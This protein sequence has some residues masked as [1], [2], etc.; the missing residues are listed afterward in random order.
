MAGSS[1]RGPLGSRQ[2]TPVV[3]SGTL[4]DQ[5]PRYVS[6]LDFRSLYQAC[7]ISQ[8]LINDG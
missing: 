4:K 8:R 7:A 1:G 6:L 5:R 2:N 3:D